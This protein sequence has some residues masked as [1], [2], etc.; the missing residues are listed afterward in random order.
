[1]LKPQQLGYH[2]QRGRFDEAEASYRKAIAL[3]PDYAEAYYNFGDTLREL[4]G[5]DAGQLQE[6][7][8]VEARFAETHRNMGVTLLELGRL[9]EAEASYRQAIALKPDCLRLI[10][11]W[12]FRAS[13]HPRMNSSTRCRRCMMIRL[14]RQKS[15]PNLLCSSEASDD[16]EDLAAAFQFYN[17]MLCAGW[18]ITVQDQKLFEA[19]GQVSHP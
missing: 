5:L 1:M 7:H 16:L 19:I 2:A 10:A 14:F 6:S 9:E 17:E 12:Q 4:G 18:D 3:K 8:S 11:S 13:F 15:L